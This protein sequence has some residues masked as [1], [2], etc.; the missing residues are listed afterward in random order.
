MSSSTSNGWL[1]PRRQGE[2]KF[3]GACLFLYLYKS[4]NPAIK[5]LLYPLQFSFAKVKNSYENVKPEGF[6][7]NGKKCRTLDAR[8]I[9]D[10]LAKALQKVRERKGDTRFAEACCTALPF[11]K[12]SSTSFPF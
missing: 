10:L 3:K 12:S 8:V 2:Q 4:D 11:S 1:K 9:Y 5:P 6:T 7:E